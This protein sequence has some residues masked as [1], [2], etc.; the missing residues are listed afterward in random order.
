MTQQI[1]QTVNWQ[2]NGY[3]LTTD[4]RLIDRQVVYEYLNK[5]S[6][7]AQNIPMQIVQRSL[8][9]SLCF[10]VFNE[11]KA[12]IGFARVVSDYATFATLA[13]VFI[14]P[15]HRGLGLGKWLVQCVLEHPDLQDLRSWNLRTRDAHGLYSQFGFHIPR[16][17]EK[18]M[19]RTRENPYPAA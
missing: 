4:E 15:A 2:Q 6:Y 5:E 17:P 3:T 18:I 1:P 10:G 14:L 13:D 7:W 9:H 8:D 16:Y 19:E 11:E 12:M